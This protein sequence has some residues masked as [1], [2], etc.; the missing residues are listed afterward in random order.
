[1]KTFLNKKTLTQGIGLAVLTK[2]TAT[3]IAVL[4]FAGSAI[5]SASLSDGNRVQILPDGY[6]MPTDG[7]DVDVDGGQWLMDEL[8][9]SSLQTNLAQRK[10]DFMFDYEH[11]TL[12]TEQNGKPAPAAGWFKKLDYVPGEGLF[13][14]NVDWTPTATKHISDKEYRY[15]SAV[16]SYDLKTG[17][18]IELMHVAL[19]NEPALDGMK[20]ITA[21]KS[22]STNSTTNEKGAA[23]NAA[24][25]L[26]AL[27]GV[28]V[29]SDAD[30]TD[31]QLTQGTVA[32]KA[33]QTKADLSGQ[34]EKDLNTA[35]TSVTAL[36]ANAATADGNVDLSKFV[37][38][39]TYDAAI[40]Q[41]AALKATGDSNSV[42]QLLKD[43][44]DKV[45][46]SEISYLTDFG[47]QQGFVALKKMVDAR[48]AI[49]ALKSKQTQG[50]K[51]PGGNV[52]AL[53]AEQQYTADQLGLSHKDFLA[54]I[55]KET[56]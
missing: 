16:F 10:N 34:L 5:N 17:R 44:A 45:F 1:M 33:L 8:A 13:A 40:T 53:T 15:T 3:N 28:T 23:M 38:K 24:T 36:K 11:Q 19:T 9:F 47:K 54:T 4:T 14:V 12:Y 26:L 2:Q 37:P 51:A 56:K 39:E 31:D 29:A 20:A 32:L 48:P 25:Q 6:F 22:I 52:A 27:L 55:N 42:D 35:Q 18:P 46:E 7:R 21:L 30:I 50:K 49:A 41:V 43:N